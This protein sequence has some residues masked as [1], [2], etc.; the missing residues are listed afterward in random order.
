MYPARIAAAAAS[1]VGLP[2]ARFDFPTMSRIA[3]LAS[4]ELVIAY[5][6]RKVSLLRRCQYSDFSMISRTSA[7]TSPRRPSMAPRM[8]AASPGATDVCVGS[9]DTSTLTN[10]F[11]GR[12]ALRRYRRLAQGC[13]GGGLDGFGIFDFRISEAGMTRGMDA[14]EKATRFAQAVS[15]GLNC[16]GVFL[17]RPALRKLK[18]QASELLRRWET[19]YAPVFQMMDL[20]NTGLDPAAFR[21]GL[22]K[23]SSL[24]RA[25]V[26]PDAADQAREPSLGDTGSPHR[27]AL[28]AARPRAV[29]C[30]RV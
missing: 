8:Y 24:V 6:A 25:G 30:R 23:I 1:A 3:L 10:P 26:D 7:D 15:E 2:S 18:P 29:G 5:I 11:F 28:P 27:D 16:L 21:A 17:C 13:R 22:A 9:S 19:E 14:A 12:P 4:G 20:P